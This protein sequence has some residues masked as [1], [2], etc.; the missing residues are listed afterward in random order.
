MELILEFLS[1]PIQLSVFFIFKKMT[2]Q[3]LGQL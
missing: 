3:R 1:R 2:E